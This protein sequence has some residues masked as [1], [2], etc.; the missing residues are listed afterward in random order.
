MQELNCQ[1]LEHY[2]LYRRSPTGA[3]IYPKEVLPMA[4]WLARLDLMYQ[5]IKAP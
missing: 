4:E 2:R 1:P 3:G 5:N